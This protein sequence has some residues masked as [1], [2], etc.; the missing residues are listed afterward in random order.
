MLFAVIAYFCFGI[1]FGN[2]HSLAM[3]EVGHVAGVAASVIGSVS[4]FIAI[5]IA[6]I[7]GS[8]YNDSITPIVLGFGVLMLP[9]IFITLHDNRHAA[10]GK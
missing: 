3:E 5:F 9:I 6:A 2:M 1:L 4:T 8:F 10:K 7:I